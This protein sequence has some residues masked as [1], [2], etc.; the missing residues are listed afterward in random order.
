MS[1]RLRRFE[2]LLP[3]KFNDGRPI[4][5]ELIGQTLRDL[6]VQFGA[7][8][9]ETQL[10]RGLWQ[11]EGEVY[12]DELVRVFVDVPSTKRNMDYFIQLKERLKERFEQL[13]I[14]M[15]SHPIDL[16]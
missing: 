12:S 8:S 16:I 6:R 1:R 7:S 14:W 5:D 10:I 11:H 15:T 4:P 2:I 9:W 3:L 13:D